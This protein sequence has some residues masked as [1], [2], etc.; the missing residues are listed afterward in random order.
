M[1][2]GE[3]LNKTNSSVNIQPKPK[4][5]NGWRTNK[6]K[7]LVLTCWW[8]VLCKNRYTWGTWAILWKIYMQKS[9]SNSRQIICNAIRP[10]ETLSSNCIAPSRHNQTPNS[11]IREL[12]KIVITV[13][14]ISVTKTVLSPAWKG[15]DKDILSQNK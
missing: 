1:V 13:C 6:L 4:L 8:C 12:H 3:K 11:I 10:K 2:S 15:L 9:I 14:W 7:Q 5:S